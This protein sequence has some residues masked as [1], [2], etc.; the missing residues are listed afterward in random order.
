MA[1]DP[2]V[3]HVVRQMRDAIIDTDLRLL[4]TVN[5]RLTLVA[6]LRAYKRAQGLPFVD[7]AREE[8]M[9]RYLQGANRGPMSAEGLGD[10]YAHILELTKRETRDAEDGA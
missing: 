2:N 3:D 10:L 4:A 1:A 7:T 5:Q 9:H 8:W 6:R